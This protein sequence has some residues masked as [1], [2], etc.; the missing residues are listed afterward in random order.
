MMKKLMIIASIGLLIFSGCTG[1][2]TVSTGLENEAFLEFIGNPGDYRGG[3]SVNVDDKTTFV[4]EVNKDYTKRPKGKVYAISTGKHIVAVT[5][6]NNVIYNKQIFI[7]AQETKK[8]LL[9]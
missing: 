6:N 4:A 3:V 8:I 5:Y 1:V 7:S 9:P 2:K